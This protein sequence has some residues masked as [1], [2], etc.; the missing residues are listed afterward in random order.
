MTDRFYTEYPH[1]RAKAVK[2]C[3]NQAFLGE[4]EDWLGLREI[5]P[6]FRSHTF[7]AKTGVVRLGILDF[8]YVEDGWNRK[9]VC[10]TV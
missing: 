6:Q 3:Q 8:M 7:L 4:L 10:C 1:V 2:S 5:C 9:V